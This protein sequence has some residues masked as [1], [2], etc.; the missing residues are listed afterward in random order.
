VF[1]KRL[2]KRIF[3]PKREELIGGWRKQHNEELENFNC[4]LDT[5]M[6]IKS[7]RIRKAL[8]II[9]DVRNAYKILVR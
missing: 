3:W 1:E 8:N 4:S 7:K 5:V 9:K 2:W 6:M